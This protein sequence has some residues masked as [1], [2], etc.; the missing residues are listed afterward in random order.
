MPATLLI[1]HLPDG[2]FQVVRLH[3]GKAT[4]PA[5]VVS[6][7]GFAVEGRPDS[8]LMRELRWYL[9]TFLDYPFP[10]ETDHAERVQAALRRWGEQAFEGLFGGRGAG[11]LFDAATAD[12]YSQLHVQVTSDDPRVLSWPWEA[13]YN[14]EVGHLAQTCQ[15][16][17]RLNK[18]RDPQP[19]PDRLPTERVNILLVIARPFEGDVR[20]RSISRPLVELIEAQRLPAHAAVLRPPTLDALRAHLRQRPGYYHILHFD[21]H[22]SY[23]VQPSGSIVPHTLHGPQGH[24]VFEKDDGTPDPIT[25]E[26]LSVL[27]REHAV[28][29]VVLNACQSAMLDERAADPFASVAAS[30][31]RSGMRSVVAMAY[32]LFVSGA[33]Q[34]L[35]AFY[36]RLFDEGSIAQAVRAGRQQMLAHVGRV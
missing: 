18:V 10:P 14:P 34:Y 3:D 21:G 5:S 32:S 12:A 27:L 35:P 8:D 6:P 24:L 31:L 11:R 1:R 17:R 19:L 9:E 16:E 28:P 36:G 25:A 33:Q 23:G 30:L 13:L 15:I 4:E 22:G 29:A 26:K 20:Y 2:R 7:V